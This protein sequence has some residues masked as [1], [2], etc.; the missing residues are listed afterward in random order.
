MYC[1]IHVVALPFY[2]YTVRILSFNKTLGIPWCMCFSW[3]FLQK[4]FLSA[5]HLAMLRPSS[6]S[7]ESVVPNGGDE[8]SWLKKKRWYTWKTSL[9]NKKEKATTVAGLC[10]TILQQSSKCSDVDVFFVCRWCF[11]FNSFWG[12]PDAEDFFNWVRQNLRQEHFL[13]E[14]SCELTKQWCCWWQPEI[15]NNHLGCIPNL[16]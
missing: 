11:S 3:D 15:P 10:S 13:R 8:S 14:L 4:G 1:I 12:W 2:W 5:H 6:V 9:V 7:M 16:W